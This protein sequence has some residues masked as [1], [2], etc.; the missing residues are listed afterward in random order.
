MEGHKKKRLTKQEK[1]DLAIEEITK[2]YTK[3]IKDNLVQNI[4]IGFESASELY[5]EK[6]E[7]GCTIE[8]LKGLIL[9]N[10]ENKEIIEEVAKNNIDKK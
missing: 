1:Q 6:I 10:L 2:H 4:I 7:S 3:T 9:K 5:L 8:E